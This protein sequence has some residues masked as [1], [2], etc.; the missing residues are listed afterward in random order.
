MLQNLY[1]N[2]AFSLRLFFYLSFISFICLSM[3]LETQFFTNLD[4]IKKK[5]SN[6]SSNAKII[7]YYSLLWTIGF[8]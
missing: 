7:A 3:R 2:L 4:M 5:S 1:C 8:Q 6:K